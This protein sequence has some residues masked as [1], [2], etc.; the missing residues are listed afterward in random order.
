MLDRAV[1]DRIT[2]TSA[3]GSQLSGGLDSS[4]VTVTAARLLRIKAAGSLL[5]R[6][7]RSMPLRFP[8][9]LPTRGRT[10]PR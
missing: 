7:F 2:G 1:Q 9:G 4:S 10:R 6:R 8:A 5:S 3:V